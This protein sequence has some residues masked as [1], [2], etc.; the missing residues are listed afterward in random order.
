MSPRT[1][2]QGSD[3]IIPDHGKA[4]RM[5]SSQPTVLLIQPPVYDFTAFDFFLYPLGLLKAGEALARH[6]YPTTLIDSLDRFTPGPAE[7]GLKPPTFRLDGCGHFHRRV[8]PPPPHL[9]G[10]PRRFHRFGLPPGL[11]RKRL[12]EGSR[13]IAAAITC[14]MTYWYPGVIEMAEMVRETWPGTP[15]IL[16]GVYASLCAE[17]A[18]GIGALDLVV[19]GRD[20][21]P[22]LRFLREIAPAPVAPMDSPSGHDLVGPRSS[23]AIRTSSGCPRKCPYCAAALLGGSF[24]RYPL[25][26]VMDELSFIVLQK[27]REHVAF[28]DD[29]LLD[30]GE[31]FL[32]LTESIM[33]LG[34]HRKAAFHCPNALQASAI[35]AGVAVAL[36]RANF[37]TIR[38]GFETADPALQRSLG[39]KAS[40]EDL[41]KAVENLKRAGF[42]KRDIGVYILVGLPGQEAGGV[43]ESVRFVHETGALSRLAE[44]A[45]VPGTPLFQEAKQSSTLDLDEPLHHNKTLAPFR[46]STLVPDALKKLKDLVRELNGID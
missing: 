26:E 16:G 13:P 7:V 9:A 24:S 6:G 4:G 11:L 20:L 28:Y 37:R 2:I 40:N 32:E 39:Q 14:S 17:H 42:S 12:A 46:F 29:A 30:G 21:E 25:E 34:L 33:S 43:E 41:K 31:T 36:K 1:R 10:I 45:P 23:A 35:T 27:K 22:A 44:Y 15:V 5:R 3:S 18:R 19:E 8:I 38:I